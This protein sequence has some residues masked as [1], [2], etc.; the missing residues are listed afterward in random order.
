MRQELLFQNYK[1]RHYCIFEAGSGGNGAMHFHRDKLIGR[2][3]N[4]CPFYRA[5]R[6]NSKPQ[7]LMGVL[8]GVTAVWVVIFGYQSLTQRQVYPI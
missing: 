2:L 5:F 6:M 3:I 7:K 4:S 8:M 1:D